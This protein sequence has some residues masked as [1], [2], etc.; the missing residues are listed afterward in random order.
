MPISKRCLRSLGRVSFV[1]AN[2][3]FAAGTL[4]VAGF[5]WLESG[6]VPPAAELVRSSR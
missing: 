4:P 3:G 2:I 6:G 1:I 5:M